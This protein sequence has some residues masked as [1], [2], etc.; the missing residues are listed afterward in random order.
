M[1][2]LIISLSLSL[3]SVRNMG[4]FGSGF[5]SCENRQS[6]VPQKSLKYL[7][8]KVL[9]SEWCPNLCDRMACNQA[10]LSMEF[11][12]LKNTEVGSHSCLQGIFPTQGWNSGLPAL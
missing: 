9:V 12:R 6:L 3:F 2:L 5:C 1:A 8:V 10:S 11:T 4:E 7:K